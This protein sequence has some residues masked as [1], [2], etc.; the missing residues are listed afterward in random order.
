MS[1]FDADPLS[2]ANI[3]LSDVR[4]QRDISVFLND[5]VSTKFCS[6]C[7]NFN[8]DP[9]H[10][11]ALQSIILLMCKSRESIH[12]T[13]RYL[14]RVQVSDIKL[15]PRFQEHVVEKTQKDTILENV[16]DI[17][18]SISDWSIL[19]SNIDVE[20]SI[21]QLEVIEKNAI[22][23]R[24]REA[25]REASITQ[26]VIPEPNF[27]VLCLFYMSPRTTLAAKMLERLCMRCDIK[28]P[29]IELKCMRFVT[30]YMDATMDEGSQN[31]LYVD[32]ACNI[33]VS[34]KF[35]EK[36]RKVIGNMVEAS[37]LANRISTHKRVQLRHM[38]A[39]LH[40]T[41]VLSYSQSFENWR[42]SQK[43]G[44][45]TSTQIQRLLYFIRVQETA[46]PEDVYENLFTRDILTRTRISAIERIDTQAIIHII[47]SLRVVTCK[48]D[49]LLDFR[50]ECLLGLS[51]S[52]RQA[53][54]LSQVAQ[55]YICAFQ[56]DS[57]WEECWR[58]VVNVMNHTIITARTK[59]KGAHVYDTRGVCTNI[60]SCL[61]GNIA[62]V[63]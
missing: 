23:L 15:D 8:I 51:I 37:Q 10:A 13:Q 41:N 40:A 34:H 21:E 7:S 17:F 3:M 49:A 9:I 44:N 4:P 50:T 47:K 22:F 54:T 46:T 57:V 58:S 27:L 42:A 16:D 43:F 25:L 28:T 45:V 1:V 59:F 18:S 24:M 31:T 52:A 38:A 39:R 32:M 11:H 60:I 14:D 33:R 6:L 19:L 26:S 5:S 12:L 30:R 55:L 2:L 63:V 62:K 61:L 56:H 48:I 29:D 20:L 36:I 35:H 53:L